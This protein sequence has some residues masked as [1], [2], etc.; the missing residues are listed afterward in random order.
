M[1]PRRNPLIALAAFVAFAA[2]VVSPAGARA[3]SA[4]ESAVAAVLDRYRA[5]VER[6]DAAGTPALFVENAQIVEQGGIEGDYQTYLAHHL[7]PELAEIASFDFDN[8][9]VSVTVI[10]DIAFATESYTYRIVF[11]DG[12]TIDRRGAATSALRRDANGWRIAQHHSS[13]R[14]PPAQ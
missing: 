3:Q 6:L 8:Y 7:G 4:D 5:S 10:G 13:S 14:A 1:R 9:T 12:R 11:K 2:A